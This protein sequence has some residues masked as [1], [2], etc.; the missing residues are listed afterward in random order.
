MTTL[1]NSE[2]GNGLGYAA[3][4]SVRRLIR[5]L[6]KIHSDVCPLLSEVYSFSIVASGY[7]W[8]FSA[9]ADPDGVGDGGGSRGKPNKKT[10]PL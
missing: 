1:V 2:A 8:E 5:Y 10:F 4:F 7:I 3:V 9:N 6:K